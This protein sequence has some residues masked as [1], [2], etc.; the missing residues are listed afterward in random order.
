MQRELNSIGFSDMIFR[1]LIFL[2]LFFLDVTAQE[3]PLIQDIQVTKNQITVTANEEFAQSFLITPKHVTRYHDP[4]L[5]LRKLDPSVLIM[6]FVLDVLTAVLISGKSYFVE[7]LDREFALSIERLRNLLRYM[8]PHTSWDGQLTSKK[9]VTHHVAFQDRCMAMCSGGI[10]SIYALLLLRN[11]HPALLLQKGHADTRNH[12]QWRASKKTVQSLADKLK[13]ELFTY[14]SQGSEIVHRERLASLSPE[15]IS[16]RAS[17]QA[18][19]RWIGKALPLMLFYGFSTLYIPSNVNKDYP[20][21]DHLVTPIVD[22]MIRFGDSIRFNQE[23]FTATR[24]EK[25][26]YITDYFEKE[27]EL[28]PTLRSCFNTSGISCNRC[29]KCLSTINNLYFIGKNPSDWGF[30]T[31]HQEIRK[32]LSEAIFLAQQKNENVEFYYL[33]EQMQFLEQSDLLTKDPH[34]HWFYHYIKGLERVQK[35]Y[36]MDTSFYSKLEKFV[37]SSN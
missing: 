26:K 16:W 34:A 18:D 4:N 10:D 5:D 20:F 32:Y 28:P 3:T 29:I 36:E 2:F 35:I 9:T 17:A 1:I 31:N 13:C 11:Q 19:L 37:K 7:T 33:F 12:A 8:F 21:N 14:F 27:K 25:V 23:Q 6:P 24:L 22:Q 30:V 15:I